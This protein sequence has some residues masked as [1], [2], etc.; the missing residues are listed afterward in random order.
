MDTQRPIVSI[1]G[2]SKSF[3]GIVALNEVDLAIAPG[4][5]HAL[6][7]PN[8][9][10]KTT[11]V[12]IVSGLYQPDRGAIEILGVETRLSSLHDAARQ[13]I[14]RTFQTIKLFGSMTAR[15]HVMVGCEM[16]SGAGM[17]DALF[18]TRRSRDEE[19]RRRAIAN[20]LLTLVGLYEFADAPADSLAYG[21]RRLLEVARA[22]AARPRLLLLDEPAAGLVAS[23]IEM[24]ARVIDRL[25][26]SGLAVLLVEHHM[27]LVIAV[28]DTITVLEYGRVISRGDVETVRNDPV[29]VEAYLGTG[30]E[31]E[32]SAVAG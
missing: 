22:L 28:S 4:T 2:I 12:N 6:I 1:R 13:G 18:R 31:H 23:E 26:A 30:G 29:V 3:G 11:L 16:Q 25:R 24:L 17:W 10:G 21:H 9:A 19:Q 27:D 7:G 8:G 14:A 5:V 32:L 15:E 20:E